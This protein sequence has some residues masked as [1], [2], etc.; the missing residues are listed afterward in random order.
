[1]VTIIPILQFNGIVIHSKT[2][3]VSHV[4]IQIMNSLIN[5]LFLICKIH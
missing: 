2:T 3:I 1:M 4:I 5:D